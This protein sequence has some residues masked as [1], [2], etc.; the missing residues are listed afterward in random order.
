MSAA[1][2]VVS[3]YSV[4]VYSLYK[5]NRKQG[6]NS[7][8]IRSYGELSV[9]GPFELVDTK[10]NI[11]STETLKGKW[12]LLYFGF[13]YCPDICPEQMELMAEVTDIAE[14]EHDIEIVPTMITIDLERDTPEVLEEYVAEYSPKIVG[15]LGTEEQVDNACNAYRCYRS[16]G[17][18][19]D[20]PNDYILDHTVTQYVINPDGKTVGYFMSNRGLEERVAILLGHVDRY[21]ECKKSE[22]EGNSS[23][24]KKTW[25]QS[26]FSSI[27][28]LKSLT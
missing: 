27:P 1:G 11:V 13:T 23:D 28:G 10:G 21:N 6:D 7:S 20:D 18:A 17:Q 9:G 25:W 14:K 5:N 12:V 22:L 3:F 2:I 4:F 19:Y 8:Q 16:K 24:N 15:L 26:A